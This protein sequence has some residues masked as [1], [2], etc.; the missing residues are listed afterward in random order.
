MQQPTQTTSP[1]GFAQNAVMGS[2]ADEGQLSADTLFGGRIVVSYDPDIDGY[3]GQ[4]I[5]HDK[6]VYAFNNI[7]CPAHP[8][9]PDESSINNLLQVADI[10]IKDSEEAR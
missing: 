10:A 1:D 8:L 6:T 7:G 9:D 4:V 3:S 2:G 5:R